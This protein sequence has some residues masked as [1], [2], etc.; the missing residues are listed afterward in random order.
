LTK[1]ETIALLKS[2][3]DGV[4]K[5]QVA[6]IYDTLFSTI[7]ET[8]EKG[9][10]FKVVGFGTFKRKLRQARQGRNPKTGEKVDIPA[11]YSIIFTPGEALQDKLKSL[12]V[13]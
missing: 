5:G 6:A 10:D 11:R 9:E 1:E 8:V 3:V 4:T 2:K 13:E 7:A 12:P